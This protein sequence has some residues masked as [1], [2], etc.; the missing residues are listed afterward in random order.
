MTTWTDHDLDRI[1]TAEEVELTSHRNDGSLRPY[2]TM[3]VVRVD[4]DVYVRSAHGP[5]NGWYR[6]AIAS[7]TGRIRAGGHEADVE[8][9]T[10]DPGANRAI[11]AAYHAK[12]DR[13]GPR[14]VGSVVGPDAADVTIRLVSSV[15][16]GNTAGA[17]S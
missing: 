1:G 7:G 14:L 13:Y 2:V 17:T 9:T 10:A 12:Y 6:R 11:D 16:D 8:F 3:W 15:T 5:G 4:D